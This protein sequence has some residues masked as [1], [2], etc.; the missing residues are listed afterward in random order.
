MPKIAFIFPGQGSQYVGMGKDFAEHH[1]AAAAVFAQAEQQLGFSLAKLCFEGPEDVLKQTSNTQ[2]AL[3][4]TSIACYEVLKGE[5]IQPDYLA[6]HS[7]GEYSALVAAGSISFPDAVSLV[8]KR[9]QLMEEA[10]PSGQGGMAAVLGLSA[11]QV[12][13]VCKAATSYGLVQPANYNCPGQVVIAGENAALKQAVILAKEAGAKRVVELAVSGPF[14]SK[15]MEKAGDKLAAILSEIEVRDPFLPVIANVNAEPLRTGQ[16]V[17]NSLV[18]QLSNP[19]RWEETVQKLYDLGVRIFVEVG[20]EKVLSGLVK[21]IVKDVL[22]AN[23]QD[24]ESLQKTLTALKG[25]N[26]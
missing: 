16:E 1:P 13:K 20:P 23:V 3:L 21:K 18:K 11:L 5:G 7:L 22:I 24:R 19:V 12:E 25:G 4:T 17:R 6:G 2:P 9:G 8:Q 14:H 26:C 15:L 10:Y